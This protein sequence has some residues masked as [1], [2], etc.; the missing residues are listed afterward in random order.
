[1]DEKTRGRERKNAK[2]GGDK[3]EGKGW[4][5]ERGKEGMRRRGE[6]KE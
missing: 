3:N 2:S 4:D 1:M 6:K 5:E